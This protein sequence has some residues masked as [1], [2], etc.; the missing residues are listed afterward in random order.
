[1]KTLAPTQNCNLTDD[2]RL[3]RLRNLLIIWQ[4]S[5]FASTA[6]RSVGWIAQC[7][8]IGLRHWIYVKGLLLLA[9]L[10]NLSSRVSIIN[11]RYCSPFVLFMNACGSLQ[12][13][14]I[15]FFLRSDSL[16]SSLYGFV[17]KPLW[18]EVLPLAVLLRKW[19]DNE[20]HIRSSL[21]SL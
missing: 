18:P 10:Y 8:K 11:P 20:V 4:T 13:N 16:S 7:N 17:H 2:C 1:M 14:L 12:S 5:L 19:H 9:M 6:K 15:L 21:D 3:L